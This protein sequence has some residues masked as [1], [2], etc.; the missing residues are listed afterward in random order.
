MPI[1]HAIAAARAVCAKRTPP[2]EAATCQWV[3][4]PLLKSAGYDDADI[5]PAASDG[6]GQYPDYTILPDTTQTFY[7]EAK[8]WKA[9]LQD[10]HATQATNYANTNGR[11]WVVLTNGNQWH[12]Y[13]NHILKATPEKLVAQANIEDADGIERFLLAIGKESIT[14][15]KLPA[16]AA[17]ETAARERKKLEM[18][19]S[20]RTQ[21][22]R[23]ALEEICPTQF[24]SPESDLVKAVFAVLSRNDFLKNLKPEDVS[25]YF[26]NRPAHVPDVVRKQVARSEP[27]ATDV[28]ST[29][30]ITDP[31]L[32]IRI[33][34]F[35]RS[36]MDQTELYN[37]TRASWR[38][39]T[40]RERAKLAMAV[41]KGVIRAV[42]EI[43][44]W[45]PSERT[46]GRWKFTGRPATSE[47]QERFIGKSVTAYLKRGCQNPVIY[48][49][50]G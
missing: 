13:D 6:A 39:G 35:Y 50:C 21:R 1:K 24:Q 5:L 14:A 8:K 15:D 36:D 23:A 43:E 46:K 37:V 31:T 18:A 42:Y 29:A 47:I 20:E 19:E 3:I 49:N 48:V 40:K 11:R 30:K 41:Y 33:N 17:E 45:H 44:Q 4:L 10:H 34:K 25:S 16:F 27:I 26:G 22:V 2:N 38:L 28:E 7:L 12:L 9:E 32:L